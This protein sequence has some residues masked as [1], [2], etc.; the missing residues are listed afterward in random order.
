MALISAIAVLATLALVL[1]PVYVAGRHRLTQLNAHRLSAIAASATVAIPAESLDVIA[2]RGQ[3]SGAFVFVQQI[4][5]RTWAANGGDTRQPTN[6]IAVVRPDGAS[7]R[8][9]AHSSWSAGEPQ[10]SRGWQPPAAL[11]DSL[12]RNVR[13]ETPL[14]EGPVGSELAAEAPILRPDGTSAAFVVVTLDADPFLTQLSADLMRLSWIPV[15]V[16]VAALAASL[17]AARQMTLG[18]EEVAAHA[19]LV[20]RGNMRRSLTFESGDEIGALAASFRTMSDGLRTLL[21]DVETGAAEV[22][23]TADELAAG[24]QE[25]SASTEEVAAAAQSIATSAAQQTEGIHTVVAISTRVATRAQE[26][27]AHAQRAQTAADAVTDSARRAAD[28]ADQG[29]KSMATISAVTS[30]TLPA[31]AELGEKSLRIGQITDTIGAIARQ[32]NLLALNAAIEAARAGEHGRG[33]AVVAD[34]VRKLAKES[35]RALETIRQLAI[36]IQQASTAMSARIDDVST[37]VAAGESVIRSSTGA[38]TQIVKEIEGSRGAVE[39]IVESAIAQHQ[40]AESLAREI[41]A[42]AVVAEQNASTSEQVSA[43]VQEQ[44]ASMMH[45]TESSQHL[46]DIAARLKGV[47]LRFEL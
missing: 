36:E 42:V 47:M 44:T 1:T 46:A 26:V 10:Y 13:G 8:Y 33:F 43:V 45:V 25:M 15:L 20:A 21:R 9:L 32:T 31:V 11:T 5:E 35:G 37:S 2:T 17:V 28:A 40:E 4:L 12:R 6:G 18:I 41:E 30:E 39:R 27:S 38:L 7:Y 22:A 24:A 19:Q 14:Y 34:E 29:L 16:M 3:N 23:A